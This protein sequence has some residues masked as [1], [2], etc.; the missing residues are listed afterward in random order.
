MYRNERYS[1]PPQENTVITYINGKAIMRLKDFP[2][3]IYYDEIEFSYITIGE[4]LVE[5]QPKPIALLSIKE[6]NQILSLL[7]VI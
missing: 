3:R 7:E 4:H 2:N 6:Q 1:Q 5:A